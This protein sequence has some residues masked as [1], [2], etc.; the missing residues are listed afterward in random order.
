MKPSTSS[1]T[2]FI[3]YLAGR[4]G[5]HNGRKAVQFTRFL[6]RAAAIPTGRDLRST[7]RRN[8]YSHRFGIRIQNFSECL[9]TWPGIRMAFKDPVLSLA[10]IVLCACA[11]EMPPSFRAPKNCR[12]KRPTRAAV[13]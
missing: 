2:S 6:E 9:F 11:R 7:Y 3:R 1:E 13:I 10:R 4:P 12:A 8:R 5:C